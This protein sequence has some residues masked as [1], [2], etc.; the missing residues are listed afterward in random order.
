L[1]GAYYALE[2]VCVEFAKRTTKFQHDKMVK[3]WHEVKVKALQMQQAECAKENANI[4]THNAKNDSKV[5]TAELSKKNVQTNNLSLMSGLLWENL[6]Q[7]MTFDNSFMTM[8][9]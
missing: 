3:Q 2:T 8:L 5:P 7:A 6:M 9:K 4:N 1:D